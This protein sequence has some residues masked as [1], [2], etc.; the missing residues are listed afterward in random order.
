MIIILTIFFMLV[1]W[2]LC[3]ISKKEV[4]RIQK[5]RD[6]NAFG[7]EKESNFDFSTSLE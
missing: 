7:E 3:R 6:L 5:S 2:T 1:I 4:P